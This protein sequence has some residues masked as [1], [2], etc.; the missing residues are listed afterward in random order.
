MLFA[1]Y[2]INN[3]SLCKQEVSY[4]LLVNI[5]TPATQPRHVA[6][7]SADICANAKL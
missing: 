4:V 1:T 2:A 7:R 6:L 3:L 5:E